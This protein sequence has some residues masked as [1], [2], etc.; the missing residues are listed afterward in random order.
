MDRDKLQEKRSNICLRKH[1]VASPR[2]RVLDGAQLGEN[3][4][5]PSR[6]V[7]FHHTVCLH[8]LINVELLPNL[9]NQLPLSYLVTISCSGMA[10]KSSC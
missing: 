6:S 2:S 10:W 8:D 9:H 5:F 1:S 3:N 4:D 7:L